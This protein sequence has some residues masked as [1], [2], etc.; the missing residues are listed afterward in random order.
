MSTELAEVNVG[1]IDRGA[2]VVIGL[3]T[4]AFFIASPVSALVGLA[5]L[6]IALTGFIGYCPAYALA[7][8]STCRN[9]A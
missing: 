7:G 1:K 8:M 4:I 5:G 9:A 2:R 6:V 3:A